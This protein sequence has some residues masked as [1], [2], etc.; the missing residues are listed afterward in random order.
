MGN[1]INQANPL[2]SKIS[3]DSLC[4][5]LLLY[6]D[7]LLRRVRN[8]LISVDAPDILDYTWYIMVEF[9]HLLVVA[10]ALVRRTRFYCLTHQHVD[11]LQSPFVVT[12]QK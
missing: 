6:F 12:Q 11:L 4:W 2:M 9:H 7:L 10:P 3:Y 8:G 1:D 5:L